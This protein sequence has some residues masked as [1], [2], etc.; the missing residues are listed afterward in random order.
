M[1]LH[2]YSQ[3]VLISVGI[4]ALLFAGHVQSSSA[5]NECLDFCSSGGACLKTKNGPK[6]ICSPE[7]TGERCDIRQELKLTEQ[8]RIS[9]VANLSLRDN[10]CSFAPEDVCNYNGVCYVIDN[11]FACHCNYPY[12]GQYCEND[13]LSGI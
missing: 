6:C 2:L 10:R 13:Q 8:M 3:N 12:I 1:G 5:T 7:W 4:L 11:Q 9:Q